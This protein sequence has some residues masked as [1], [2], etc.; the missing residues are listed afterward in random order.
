ML[1][2]VGQKSHPIFALCWSSWHRHSCPNRIS[3]ETFHPVRYL[4]I[5]I[6]P[7]SLQVARDQSYLLTHLNFLGLASKL[8]QG[9]WHVSTY[10]RQPTPTTYSCHSKRW[11]GKISWHR[12]C[13]GFSLHPDH[14]RPNSS[15][16]RDARLHTRSPWSLSKVVPHLLD[17]HSYSIWC[18]SIGYTSSTQTLGRTRLT[19]TV[20]YPEQIIDCIL[21][22]LWCC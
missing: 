4:F 7:T 18:N 21:F 10:Q 14:F 8:A 11:P 19:N 17:H 5:I 22:Y 12:H 1:L 16:Y 9:Q 3:L 13:L 15:S 6:D 2:H 20:C